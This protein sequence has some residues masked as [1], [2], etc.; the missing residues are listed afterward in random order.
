MFSASLRASFLL[1]GGA[2]WG[3]LCW[4]CSSPAVHLAASSLPSACPCSVPDLGGNRKIQ[5]VTKY[6]CMNVQKKREASSRPPVLGTAILRPDQPSAKLTRACLTLRDASLMTRGALRSND[7][8]PPPLPRDYDIEIEGLK[9]ETMKAQEEH[10]GLVAVRDRLESGRVF[11]KEQL[12]KTKVCAY[13]VCFSSHLFRRLSSSVRHTYTVRTY[14][15][16][17][18]SGVPCSPHNE[19]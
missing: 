6:A 14:M 4:A 5:G 7:L 13:A 18:L 19:A 1:W 16:L 3:N 8:A 17:H 10:E 2:I 9:R 11:V 15:L 12:A